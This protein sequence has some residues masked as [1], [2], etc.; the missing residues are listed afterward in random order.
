MVIGAGMAGLVCAAS[1]H[2]ARQNVL[3]IEAAAQVGGRIRTDRHPDGYLLDHGFQVLLDAYPAA[4]RWVDH[5]ALRPMAFE[6]G[7]H[8]WSGKRLLPLAHPLHQPSNTL[9]DLTSPV[10]PLTDK[11]RLARL[12]LRVQ[13]AEWE[14]AAEA[15]GE[16]G[17][18][19]AADLLWGEGFSP[20][21]VDRFAQRFW[22]GILLDP[23]LNTSAGPLL[24]TLK[25]FLAGHAVLPAEGVGMMPA[26]LARR[27][28]P[29]AI[30]L[31]TRIDQIDALDGR[32]SGVR[33]GA[34]TIPAA[35][36]V[37][38]TAAPEARRLTGIDQLPSAGE[39]VGSVTI[40]LEGE[41]D[42][43]VGPR[44]ILDGTGRCV[45]NHVA[46]L[47]AVQ[48]SYAPSG[49]HLIA[50]VVVG[51]AQALPDDMLVERAHRDVA[52]M[53]GHQMSD[54]NVLA[55]RRIPFSQFAQPPG[56]YATLPQAETTRAGLF[57]ASEA[58]VDSSYNGAILG[59]EAA[60][61]EVLRF[62]ANVKPQA[63]PEGTG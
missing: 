42:P 28:D 3:L 46:P 9:R 49:R 40:F 38:A 26:E 54:W 10:F 19:S 45:V 52:T 37:V 33:T 2:Q 50:A 23:S 31:N 20:A 47:S 18:R 43:G 58:T 36:V 17:S 59:G 11:V 24:F 39:G 27:L 34:E 63:T 21:F 6:S 25:M 5:P 60:A 44:L 55:I 48:P 29:A 30:R 53:L 22:G 56:I 51:E 61:R 1:L 7:A 57:L 15:A 14:S 4:R 41:R 62:L 32:M 8:V 35:A 13:R 16:M 12:A